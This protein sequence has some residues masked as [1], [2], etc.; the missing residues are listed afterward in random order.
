MKKKT[1]VPAKKEPARKPADA[2]T[3][4]LELALK[5]IREKRA[6]EQADRSGERSAVFAARLKN[7]SSRKA[8]QTARTRGYYRFSRAYPGEVDADGMRE[9]STPKKGRLLRVSA[10]LLLAVAVFL[11]AYCV[12]RAA[13]LHSEAAPAVSVPTPAQTEPAALRALMHFTPDETE[14][15]SADGLAAALERAG[16]SAA[17]LEYKDEYGRIYKERAALV[18]ALHAQGYRAAAYISCFKDSFRPELDPSLAV[19]PVNRPNEAWKDNTGNGWL[20]PFSAEARRLLLD[21]VASAA[22]DGFDYILLDNVCFAGDSGSAAPF[23][24]GESEFTGTR[25]QLLRGFVS[26]AVSAAGGARTILMTRFAALEAGAPNDRAPAYGDLLDTAA[27]TLCAD[28]RFS[29]QPKNVTVNGEAFADAADIPYAF[30]LAVGEFAV[31]NAGGTPVL[32]CVQKSAAAE[33]ASAAG[34]AGAAGIILW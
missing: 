14:N 33:A 9:N 31:K 5:R 15:A 7:A 26:D 8:P 19:Q 3:R 16:C 20:N 23:Y 30:V 4:R 1:T 2:R 21:T 11:G 12:T 29:V 24:A 32:L 6:Q 13:R 28:A 22:A 27:G 25:N 17:V 18:S 10:L 34:Y